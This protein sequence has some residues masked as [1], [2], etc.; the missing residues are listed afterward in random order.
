MTEEADALRELRAARIS[1]GQDPNEPT[2][3]PSRGMSQFDDLNEKDVI[4]HP[5]KI[6][7][8]QNTIVS[9]KF[10]EYVKL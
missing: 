9:R 6:Y 7:I 8:N 2:P 4:V 3:S 5:I 1:R 10:F